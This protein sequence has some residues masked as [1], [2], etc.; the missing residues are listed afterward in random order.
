MTDREKRKKATSVLVAGVGFNL[1]IG[2]LYIWSIVKTLLTASPEN[3]GWAWTSSQAGL[4]YTLGIVCFALG[5]FIGGRI[6]DKIGPRP[7]VTAGGFMVGLG[8]VLSGLVGNNPVG[9]TLC[10]GVTTGLGIGLGYGS[11]TPSALKWFHPSRKGFV[12]GFVVGGFGLAAIYLAPLISFLLSRFSIEHSFIIL[13]TIV[14]LIS[15]TLAQ[16]IKNP[17]EGYIPLTPKKLPAT[18]AKAA[19]KDFTLQE[20]TRTKTFYLLLILY[21]FSASV[22]LMVIGNV[23]RI[24]SLQSGITNAALLAGLVSFMALANGLGR[25]I[26]GMVS[27]RIG[28]VNTLYIIFGLQLVNMSVFRLYTALPSLVLGILVTGLCF[29]AILSIFPA[30]TA[31]QFGLKYYGRNYGVIYLAWGASGVLAPLLA[32]Y[33]YDLSG[34]FNTA[35]VVCA[36]MMVGIIGVNAMLKKEIG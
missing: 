10:F 33:F 11:I 2:V 35:Y 28:R 23:T 13:G 26:G 3:G 16:F 14:L 15:I 25:V 30:L 20:M 6:Q 8:L 5:V 32:D 18:A 31:D 21:F 27:D 9:I 4:P 19:P 7:V 29:G 34:N 24:V 12:S 36:V 17:P 1:T 22:G